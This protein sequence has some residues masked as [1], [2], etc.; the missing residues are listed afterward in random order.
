MEGTYPLP[1]AQLDR[2]LMKIIVV[3]PSSSD[4]KKIVERTMASEQPEVEH[5]AGRQQILELK[6]AAKDILVAPHV[7]DFAIRLVLATQPNEQYGHEVAKKYIRYG[8]S[9]RGAQALIHSGRVRAL[10]RNRLNVSIDDICTLSL[11]ALRHRIILNFDAHA[12]GKTVDE[13]VM[14]ILISLSGDTKE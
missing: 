12:E 10:M 4:L 8:S 7:Q 2:F 5:V 11:P 3:Y 14:E 13:I 1:E 6:N 9:P